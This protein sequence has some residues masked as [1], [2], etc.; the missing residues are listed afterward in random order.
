MVET[1]VFFSCLGIYYWMM[2]KLTLTPIN[3]MSVVHSFTCLWVF[4]A[5]RAVFIQ[6]L[7]YFIVDMIYSKEWMWKIHHAVAIVIEIG[8]L[9]GYD[10]VNISNDVLFYFEIGGCMYHISR[11][12]KSSVLIRAMFLFMYAFSR[13]KLAWII[14]VNR[15]ALGYWFVFMF[16]FVLLLN[17]YFLLVQIKNFFTLI[18]KR[19]PSSASQ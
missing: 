10:T 15:T 6:S 7:A 8:M 9:G 14:W 4:F 5:Q 16:A 3:W 18:R 1:I 11:I 12:F 17:A 19:T 2:I 13:W